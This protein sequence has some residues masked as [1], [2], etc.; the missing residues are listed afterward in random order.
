MPHCIVEHS[1]S[2]NRSVSISSLMDDIFD[3]MTETGLF[4]PAAIKVRAHDY[5]MERIAPP[6]TSFIHVTIKIVEGRP[7]A[8]KESIC[9][10]VFDCLH[11]YVDDAH[12]QVTVYLEDMAAHLYQK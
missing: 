2:L 11:T 7:V 6:C 1:R 9:K 8:A 3:I 5:D 12:T 10:L 4:D